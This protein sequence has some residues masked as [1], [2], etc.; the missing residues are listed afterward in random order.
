MSKHKSLRSEI[1]AVV[2]GDRH[3]QAEEYNAVIQWEQRENHLFYVDHV[4]ECPGG[5]ML[6]S[7]E[8]QSGVLTCRFRHPGGR[9]AGDANRR[10]TWRKVIGFVPD[11]FF[12][13][14]RCSP[15]VGPPLSLSLQARAR[16]ECGETGEERFFP[17]L[18]D[19]FT[20][21]SCKWPVKKYLNIERMKE[22]HTLLSRRKSTQNL[23]DDLGGPKILY[24]VLGTN[25]RSFSYFIRNAND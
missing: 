6:P 23:G 1:R 16:E 22:I 4:V 20:G 7:P 25:K 8:N 3:S 15:D 21:I 9:A 13:L 10:A 14:V 5:W 2:A 12:T 11:S 24:R 17:S 19:F 18:T